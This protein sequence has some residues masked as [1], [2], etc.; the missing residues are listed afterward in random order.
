MFELSMPVHIS[1]YVTLC[2][3]HVSLYVGLARLLKHMYVCNI[4]DYNIV[5]NKFPPNRYW[6]ETGWFI[7]HCQGWVAD[8]DN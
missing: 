6:L 1:C 3:F 2:I 7:W 4:A 5:L 8:C